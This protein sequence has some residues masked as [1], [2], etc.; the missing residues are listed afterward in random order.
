MAVGILY[1]MRTVRCQTRILLS[2]YYSLMQSHLNYGLCLWGHA[3]SRYLEKICIA[4]KR[5]VRI[6]SNSEYFAHSLPLFYNLNILKLEDLFH[7]QYGSLM[8]DQDHGILPQCFT[9][10]FTP[11]S[12][13]HNYNTRSA[14]SMNLAENVS[15]NTDTHG[16]KLFKFYGPKFFNN[17]KQQ[18]LYTKSVTKISFIKKYKTS[19]LQN[20]KNQ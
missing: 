19:L 12:D 17:L 8:W 16:K 13:I 7:Y 1:N 5:A 20:Y 18:E 2:L 11:V 9:H 4:Q 3:D 6:I 15:I 10:Y 14:T